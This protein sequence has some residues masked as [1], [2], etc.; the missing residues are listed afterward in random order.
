MRHLCV[1]ALLALAAPAA[2][3]PSFSP[4]P[5]PAYPNTICVV[6]TVQDEF[7]AVFDTLAPGQNWAMAVG[8]R[9]IGPMAPQCMS[10]APG[11]AV[12]VRVTMPVRS[13]SGGTTSNLVCTQ[14]LQPVRSAT[15]N[16]TGAPQAP[17]CS[18][19]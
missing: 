15:V 14:L 1:L 13:G 9:I 6:N 10:F 8:L 12:R 2:A 11:I 19:S 18:L 3:Q 17:V 5:G 4:A 16:I 7:W